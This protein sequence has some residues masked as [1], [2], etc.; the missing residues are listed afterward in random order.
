MKR[1]GGISFPAAFFCRLFFSRAGGCADRTRIPGPA[2][3]EPRSVWRKDPARRGSGRGAGRRTAALLMILLIALAPC[4]SAFPPVPGFTGPFFSRAAGE[5]STLK[6][7]VSLSDGV[8]VSPTLFG[9]FLEDI[10]FSVDAALY[11]QMVRNPSFEYGS[12][13]SGGAGHGW[14]AGKGT[15]LEVADG[16]ADGTCL[17]PN[18]PHYARITSRTGAPASI[19]G[20]GYLDGIAV[21]AGEKYRVTLFLRGDA[22][23][24]RAA[25][26]ESGEILCEST[27]SGVTGEWRRFDASLVPARSAD[28]NVRLAITAEGGA[29]DLDMVSLMPEDTYHGLPVRRD[30]AES[31]E[32]LHPA[33][34]RFPGGCAVEGRDEESVYSWKQSIGD[35]YAF[36]INGVLTVGDPAARRQGINIWGGSRGEPYYTSY[37]LGF[38]E[39][40]CLCEQMG[41]LALPVLNAGMTCPIQS[42]RY[43]VYPTDSEEFRACVQDALDLVEFCRGG[44]DTRWGAVR[45]AM[46]HEA[47]FELKYIGIGNEQ[48]QEEYFQHYLLFVR[49]FEAAAAAD[50]EMYGDIRLIVANGPAADS[51]EGWDYINGRGAG[52][53]LTALVDEHFYMSPDWFLRNTGRY[54][55]YDR[56]LQAKVFLGEYASQSNRLIS[57]LSEAAFMTGLEKNGDVVE[58]A[59]YAPLFGNTVSRQWDP[60]L[61][62][63]NNGGYLLT[64]NYYVQQMFSLNAVAR[65]L[66]VVLEGDVPEETALSGRAGLGSWETAVAYDDLTV[67]S[68]VTGEVLYECDFDSTASPRDALITPHRG[69]WRVSGSRLV[70]SSVSFPADINTGDAVYFG[71]PAWHDYTLTVSG[72]ILSGREGFLIPVCVRD[73]NNSVF[74]NIG[75][76]G[77]TVSCLQTVNGGTKSGQVE[78]TVRNV[79]LRKGHVYRIRVSADGA[80]V[81]CWL[82]DE[83]YVD[84]A[85]AP[86]PVCFA[87]AGEAENGD[88]ILKMVNTGG[89]ERRFEITLRDFDPARYADT[90]ETA[91][92]SGDSPDA[93]NSFEQKDA[94][95]PVYGTMEVGETFSGTLKGYSL[96]VI[97]IPALR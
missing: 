90:A 29:L 73:T 25:L 68:N 32:A 87:G 6:C 47:P 67:V 72:E 35:G 9:L 60:D 86:V 39:M 4:G 82:D 16:S 13:A 26:V 70:Q 12:A 66:P 96:T 31:L 93:V 3:V 89:E 51:R 27:F 59:C 57:A 49:A 75:G 8:P 56:S 44:T 5:G 97:R 33:F 46:G 52:D 54:D 92:L 2:S 30:L 22:R 45:A 20:T 7:E 28:R 74:W 18:N 11:A 79:R 14:S 76:W 81:R 84:H 65:S 83:L 62:Y 36:E 48:W 71:D 41:C 38:Y 50:P 85:F 21:S 34:L 78:G 24:V 40:F 42:R 43:I 10:N 53:T 88:L 77:N 23:T 95:V 17:N 94:V 19:Y 91:V 15:L 63:F 37:G 80:R 64:V 55:G 1:L 69:A 58:M 61:I